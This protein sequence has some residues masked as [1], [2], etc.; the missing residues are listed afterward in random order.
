MKKAKELLN[1]LGK[2]DIAKTAIAIGMRGGFQSLKLSRNHTNK[3]ISFILSKNTTTD[4]SRSADINIDSYFIFG[5]QVKNPTLY[6][7]RGSRLSI[8]AGADVDIAES[9]NIARIGYGS[10]LN[11]EGKFKLGGSTFISGDAYIMCSHHVEIGRGCA[12]AR[13]FECRDTDR[14]ELLLEDSVVNDPVPV[15]IGDDVWIGSN[16]SIKKGVTIGSGSVIGSESVVTK[17][18]PPNVLAVGSP[19]GVIEEDVSWRN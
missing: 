10:I 17:D 13:G 14:H 2:V 5:M 8:D 15:Q 7:I 3:P 4:V 1:D 6:T 9:N 19:A 16:V 11:V 12:I 18:I